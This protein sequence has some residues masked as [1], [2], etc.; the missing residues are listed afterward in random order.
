MRNALYGAVAVA[1]PMM[2]GGTTIGAPGWA[3]TA[4]ESGEPDAPEVAALPCDN[5][6]TYAYPAC[7]NGTTAT[8][9]NCWQKSLTSSK[10][11]SNVH[12]ASPFLD[13]QV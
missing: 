3:Q 10:S 13:A 2:L 9:W 8:S 12:V 11:Y 6:V 5:T 7:S 1:L 4:P